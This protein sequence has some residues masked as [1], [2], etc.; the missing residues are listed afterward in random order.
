MLDIKMILLKC[1]ETLDKLCH[2]KKADSFTEI[3]SS[4]DHHDIELIKR[5][6][7]E[8]D[9][10]IDFENNEFQSFILRLQSLEERNYA[11]KK[12]E[13][14]MRELFEQKKQ[15]QRKLFEAGDDIGDY[16]FE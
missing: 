13:E 12:H 8:L 7:K 11:E 2:Y 3:S 14:D 16:S 9:K 10:I 1:A 4:L 6:I 15:L 5:Q